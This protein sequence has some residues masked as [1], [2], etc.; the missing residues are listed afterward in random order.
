M[1]EQLLAFGWSCHWRHL[2]PVGWSPGG[3]PEESNVVPW[4]V[5]NRRILDAEEYG[6]LAGRVDG[7]RFGGVDY[8]AHIA[9]AAGFDS[10]SPGKQHIVVGGA[11]AEQAQRATDGAGAGDRGRCCDHW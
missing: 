6:R 9:Q 8:P 5:G 10:L 4:H 11:S 7:H 2:Q 1:V 3:W